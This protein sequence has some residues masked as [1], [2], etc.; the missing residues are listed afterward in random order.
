MELPLQQLIEH[1]GLYAVLA[2]C[3]IEGDI[4]LLLSGVLANSGYFGRY[5]FFYV[6]IFGT[7]GG[8]LGDGFGYAMGG[9][10]HENAKHT[11]FTRW[12]SLVLRG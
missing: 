8:M 1:Y 12:P 9:T 7:I 6:L 11:S 4:T 3:T 10:F 2:L 5:G